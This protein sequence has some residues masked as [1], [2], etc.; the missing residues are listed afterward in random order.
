MRVMTLTLD[1]PLPA[2]TGLHLRM[3]ANLGLVRACGLE[4][5]LAY[6]GAQGVNDSVGDATEATLCRLVDRVHYLGARRE[7]SAVPI[8]FRMAAKISPLVASALNRPINT[9]PYSLRYD[10]LRTKFVGLCLRQRID[11]VVIPNTVVHWAPSLRAAGFS[12]VCDAADVVSSLVERQRATHSRSLIADVSLRLNVAACRAQE[13]SGFAAVDELWVTSYGEAQEIARRG[14]AVSTIVV[15]NVVAE[16]NARVRAR[17]RLF[18]VGMLATYSYE[19]NLDA[20]RELAFE[21]API[22]RGEDPSMGVVLAGAGL[23]ATQEREFRGAGVEILGQVATLD[24]FYDRIDVALLPIRTRGGLPLK[25]VEALA[26]SIPVVCT[27]QLIAG[28]PLRSGIDV[29]VGD[30]PHGIAMTV[31]SLREDPRLATRIGRA[32]RRAYER[33]FSNPAALA[34]LQA[35]SVI[36]VAGRRVL[37]HDS[38]VA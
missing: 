20:A 33:H 35:R 21:L 1:R 9:S 31:M 34:Q 23:S 12:T 26:R 17:G 3:V 29:I 25:L 5:Q 24:E 32:G 14:H 27:P 7:I 22:L 36:A 13:R 4:S 19:P 16:P 8:P 30:S 18:A 28:T 37:T 38:A 2:V 6:V 11:F 15:P 10:H